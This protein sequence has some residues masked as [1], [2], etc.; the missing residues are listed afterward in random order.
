MLLSAPDPANH[1][2][3]PPT[4]TLAIG[5]HDGNHQLPPRMRRAVVQALLEC[6]YPLGPDQ[7]LQL[8]QRVLP[9]EVHPPKRPKWMWPGSPPPRMAGGA[10]KDLVTD[11]ATAAAQAARDEAAQDSG[12]RWDGRNVDAGALSPAEG[13]AQ[14]LQHAAS[15]Q[16]VRSTVTHGSGAA[17]G[18]AGHTTPPP[19]PPPSAHLPGVPPAVSEEGPLASSATVLRAAGGI[20]L[21]S[22]P[23]GLPL[24]AALPFLAIKGHLQAQ[25]LRDLLRRVAT[26][27]GDVEEQLRLHRLTPASGDMYDMYGNAQSDGHAVADAASPASGFLVPSSAVDK[28]KDVTPQRLLQCIASS[29][30]LVR[31]SAPSPVEAQSHGGGGDGATEKEIYRAATDVLH[32]ASRLAAPYARQ[33]TH[34]AYELALPYS[35]HGECAAEAGIL[36]DVAAGAELKAK[37]V[38]AVVEA[39][40]AMGIGSAEAGASMRGLTQS[41]GQLSLMLEALACNWYQLPTDSGLLPVVEELLHDQEVLSAAGPAVPRVAAAAAWLASGQEASRRLGQRMGPASGPAGGEAA[42]AEASRRGD[43]A[44]AAAE[45]LLE[46]TEMRL[47]ELLWRR[48]GQQ[49]EGQVQGQDSQAVVN[50]QMALALTAA[51][52]SVGRMPS[53]VQQA[54]QD[55]VSKRRRD[56]QVGGA[57][58]ATCWC[59]CVCY[60]AG[61]RA[62]GSP[63]CRHIT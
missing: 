11:R 38:L 13:D 4:A 21:P 10:G 41:V 58:A 60:Y 39:A 27:L 59:G 33:S 7:Q 12:W 5:V 51:C 18:T 36:A 29:A 57:V 19:A 40:E 15:Q 3:I 49:E 63:S 17:T 9:S 42:V 22:L 43:T 48:R 14:P 46:W 37:E 34:V 62:C 44:G 56:G 50:L 32:T 35:V 1:P 25:E 6:A 20:T 26:S 8:M 61:E 23:F 2:L 55:A 30:A 54:V 28:A 31:G 45:R 52:W 47:R 24:P 16:A 53:A